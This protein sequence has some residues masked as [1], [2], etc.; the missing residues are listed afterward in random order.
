VGVVPVPT[1]D[2]SLVR[3]VSEIARRVHAET[4]V[5]MTA[6]TVVELAAVLVRGCDAAGVSVIRRRQV[7]TVASS[8]RCVALADAWQVELR[9]GP[10]LD[11]LTSLEHQVESR[12]L[13][14][15]T[16][17]PR[18]APRMVSELGVESMVSFRLLTGSSLVGALNLYAF[19]ADAF[20]EADREEGSL[21]ASQAAPALY[22]CDQ[23]ENLR[24]AVAH[25]AAIGQAQG[26]LMERFGLDPDQA[27][28][29]LVRLSRTSNR[30]LHGLAEEMVQTRQLPGVQHR[31]GCRDSPDRA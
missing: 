15:D 4:S 12:R 10:C 30:K 14:V 6:E 16:R 18:W 29:V 22:A 21:L 8:D 3:H 1:G 13:W 26:I 23:V 2:A 17:W 9:Q 28:H 11:A 31:G 5:T 20:S 27:F 7:Q 25:R 19:D 24:V